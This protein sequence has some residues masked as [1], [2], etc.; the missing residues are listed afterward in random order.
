MLW[1]RTL[2]W[3]NENCRPKYLKDFTCPLNLQ[4]D[5]FHVLANLII[6]DLL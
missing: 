5:D 2:E 4:R 3:L 6:F 1:C